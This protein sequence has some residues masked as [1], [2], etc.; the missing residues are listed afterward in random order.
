MIEMIDAVEAREA[1]DATDWGLGGRKLEA[2]RPTAR[3]GGL[4][5]AGFRVCLFKRERYTNVKLYAF[6]EGPDALIY[7]FGENV[8]KSHTLEFLAHLTD[9]NQNFA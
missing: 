5:W 9:Q 8:Q 7:G 1:R 4:V 3:L 6:C 2:Q